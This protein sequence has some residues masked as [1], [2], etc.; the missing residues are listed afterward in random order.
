LSGDKL[1]S[2]GAAR[3]SI[4]VKHGTEP[5]NTRLCR[6]PETQKMEVDEQ[7]KKLLQEGIIESKFLVALP[8]PQQDAE[9]VAKEF[10]LNIVLKFCTP[11]Q[12][13]TEQGSN[14]L[15]DRFKRTCKLLK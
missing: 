2:T 9:T 1:S 7:I 5:I 4:S 8:T 3:H 14:F 13:L 11:A 12:I 6:L 15:S 10:V